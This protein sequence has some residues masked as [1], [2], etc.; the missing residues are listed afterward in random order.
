MFS[1]PSR[2][3]P[4]EY[5]TGLPHAIKLP[6]SIDWR[7]HGAVTHVKDQGMCGS[8]WAFASIGAVEGQHFRKT[9]HL[10]SLSEQNLVDCSQ[11]YGNKGCSGGHPRMAFEY[12]KSNG[13][14]DTETTYPYVAF[15]AKCRYSVTS[16][17][18]VT[19]AIR[20]PMGDER[21]LQEAIAIVGP[22]SVCIDASND[23]FQHYSGGIY[24]D[25]ACNPHRLDHAVLIVGYG[26]D[27]HQQDYYIV[28]NSW[29]SDWGENGYFRLAR[30]HNNHCGVATEASYPL[31]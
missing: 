1:H 20:I 19:G 14:I 16:G 17:A 9:G 24:S 5:F 3:A 10:V 21:K 29:G 2:S 22:I 27:E 8:C 7:D 28:K 4:Q 11:I 26:T 25:P 6:K 30:N 15:D 18:N 31:V 12:I 23:S 13:G